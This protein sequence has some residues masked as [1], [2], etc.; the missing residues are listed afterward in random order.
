MDFVIQNID[1]ILGFITMAFVGSVSLSTKIKNLKLG[2]DYDSLDQV[3]NK[4]VSGDLK[5]VKGV[6]NDG[7]KIIKEIAKELPEE[8]KSLIET[9]KKEQETM[10]TEATTSFK[11]EIEN[12]KLVTTAEIERLKE[13]N[14]TLLKEGVNR[15]NVSEI[16]QKR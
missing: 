4:L 7:A 10:L 1:K 15:E 16:W 11:N 5:E 2:R 14:A 9:F 3:V 8:I 12:F 13:Q 6:V